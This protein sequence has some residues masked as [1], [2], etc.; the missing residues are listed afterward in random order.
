M[1]L[2]KLEEVLK[3]VKDQSVEMVDFKVIDL[4]GRWHHVT[5]PASQLSNRR[6]PMVSDRCL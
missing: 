6:S 3:F 1:V 5:I 4:I 2:T